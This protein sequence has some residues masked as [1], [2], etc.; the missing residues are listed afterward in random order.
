[1]SEPWQYEAEMHGIYQEARNHRNAFW[2]KL[3]ILDGGTVALVITAVLGQLRGAIRHS[4]LIGAGLT[5]LVA[6][7]V[8]T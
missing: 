5:V 2:D 3:A 6:A 7:M 4:H 1:M 8:S